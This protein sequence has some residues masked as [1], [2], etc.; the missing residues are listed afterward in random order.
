MPIIVGSVAVDVV[1]NAQQFATLLRGQIE[2]PVDAIGQEVGQNL[3]DAVIEHLS[4]A[5]PDGL[6]GG[7][8]ESAEVGDSAGAKFGDAFSTQI[9]SRIDAAIKSLPEAHLELDD[10]EAFAKISEIRDQ[11]IELGYTELD[12]S[13]TD[14]EAM[15]KLRELRDELIM[16]QLESP[17]IRVRIDAAQAQLELDKLIAKFVALDA[18][19]FATHPI[20]ELSNIGAKADELGQKV[21]SAG[22]GMGLLGAALVGVALVAAPVLGTLAAGAG[23]LV[24]GIK[25]AQVETGGLKDAWS[26]LEQE[27]GRAIEP[28]LQMAIDHLATALPALDP[29]VDMLGADI[30]RA[31]DEAA[32][33]LGDGG[34]KG[35]VSYLATEA[36]IVGRVFEQLGVSVGGFIKDTQGSA[37]GLLGSLGDVLQTLNE[38]NKLS[39][40]IPKIPGSSGNASGFK[41]VLQ[42]GEKMLSGNEFGGLAQ[43][44]QAGYGLLSSGVSKFAGLFENNS[45]KAAAPVNSSLNSQQL[46][47]ATGGLDAQAQAIEAVNEAN[48]R[49][50][51]GLGLTTSAYMSATAA[52]AANATQIATNTANMQ[53]ENNAAGLLQ[54]AL[55]SLGGDTLGVAQAQTAF[56]QSIQSVNT[57]LKTNGSVITGNS[58]AAL[59]NQAAVEASVAAAQQHAQAI[60]N[61]TGSTI[62]AT[63]AYNADIDALKAQLAA[64]G[65]SKAQI[66]AFVD[67]IDKIPPL[68]PTVID[69][70][71]APALATLA[72]F[73]NALYAATH[74]V[75]NTVI[76]SGTNEAVLRAAASANGNFFKSFANGG[77][78]N[79]IA[80]MAPA[81]AM[82]LW[83]EPETG[84]ESYIPHAADKR[85]RSEAILSE[86]A[87]LFGGMYVPRGA[88]NFADGMV[89]RGTASGGATSG[90]HGDHDHPINVLLDG[91]SITKV[92]NEQNGRNGRL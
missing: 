8:P 61:N 32:T 34:L 30:G 58:S 71:D 6:A 31:L 78:E 56:N 5:I 35:I 80:Q 69:V 26:S 88:R 44:G 86:T 82:R 19:Q 15:L 75:G 9:R 36:P 21:S 27:A 33:W 10:S 52:A 54:Q 60:A 64:T 43:G 23:E 81:G 39:G 12:V 91:R 63:A 68:V 51:A 59:A 55:S 84:G 13:L 20:D 77:M 24:L 1:P 49:E 66:D 73:K 16:I 42:G 14:D 3:G 67:S 40:D 11:L 57:S 89:T 70:D 28:G 48:S 37:N 50:A 25:N 4:S 87:N 90:G 17:D 53:A 85:Q 74:P 45:S 7:I 41:G 76:I 18:L 2:G 62:Q 79:H 72:N 38:I 22:G 83:A 65:A 92:V 47:Q 46:Q 29:L